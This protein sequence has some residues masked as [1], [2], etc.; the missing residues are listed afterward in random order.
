[1]IFFSIG[2]VHEHP[3]KPELFPNTKKPEKPSQN[4]EFSDVITIAGNQAHLQTVSL[5]KH[6]EICVKK[7]DQQKT[8]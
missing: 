8:H 5:K 6:P 4:P 2:S 3:S 1:M 7:S